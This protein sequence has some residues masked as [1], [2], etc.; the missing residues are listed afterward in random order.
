MIFNGK[1]LREVTEADL[2]RL[3]QS[4]LAEHIYLE[5]KS[6]VYS[7]NHEGRKESLLDVCM[8]ANSQG[9]ILLLGIQEARNA[10]GQPTGIPDAAAQLG[11]QVE[12]PEN[13]LQAYGARFDACIEERIEV[14][15]H[16]IRIA[17]DRF[18]LAFRIPLSAA[19][20]HSV[21]HDGHVY[22]PCRRERHRGSLDTTEI[23]DMAIRVT[24]QLEKAETILGKALAI[25]R[26]HGSPSL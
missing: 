22:F 2:V 26:P 4:G 1:P 15:S 11:L 12:N 16:A 8:F 6:E 21:R 9:G 17:P 3:V 5:Y 24:S 18:V 14:E 25:D 7:N 20:P 19:R 10:N 13:V 23:K